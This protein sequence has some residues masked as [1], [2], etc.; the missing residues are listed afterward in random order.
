M[1]SENAVYL[2]SPERAT[3]GLARLPMRLRSIFSACASLPRVVLTRFAGE[4]PRKK[5]EERGGTPC[6]IASLVSLTNY[7]VS[8]AHLQV[9]LRSL[10][11]DATFPFSAFRFQFHQSSYLYVWKK[12]KLFHAVIFRDNETKWIQQKSRNSYSQKMDENERRCIFIWK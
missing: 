7:I 3:C 1:Y 5:G 9:L 2:P 8:L 11:A 12:L 10:F 6:R 4:N